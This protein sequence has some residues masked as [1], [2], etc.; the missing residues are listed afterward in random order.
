M[1]IPRRLR[2]LFRRCE[3]EA[4]MAEEMR[5][6]LEQRRADYASAGLAP[7]DARYAAQR[8]FGN[9]AALQERA[10]DTFG[11]GALE[12]LRQDLVL[13]SGMKLAFLGSLLGALGGIGICRLLAAANPAMR[14]N[15]TEALIGA[16]A[17]L[18]VVA[19]LACWLPARR[20]GRINAIDTL[21][22]E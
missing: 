9:T 12:R 17:L 4:E 11:W 10:R 7:E 5:F 21:R 3:V 22:A 14:M 6:H 18:F 8:K 2:T 19:L 16:V 13:A 20:A 15:S 1:N